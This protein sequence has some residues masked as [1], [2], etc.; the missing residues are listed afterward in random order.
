MLIIYQ[1]HVGTWWAVNRRRQRARVAGRP[2]L[3]V[4]TRL[5]YLRDLGVN[6]IQ[7]LPI[8]E[9]ETEFSEGYNGVDYF[10]PEQRYQAGD[11]A[12][13]A[14]YLGQINAMLAGFGAKRLSI[15][16]LRPGVNQLKCFRSRPPAWNRRHLR[17]RLQSRR[18]RLRPAE[19]LF[20]RPLQRRRSE[21]QPLLH[22]SRLGGRTGVR[23]GDAQKLLLHFVKPRRDAVVPFWME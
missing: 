18:R 16:A 21:Q 7:L 11:D 10:S 19:P 15:D 5:G 2:F 9:F 22:R 20:L 17:S 1:L 6:A 12:R 23:L 13:L 3:D 8:Q 14:W 4:A